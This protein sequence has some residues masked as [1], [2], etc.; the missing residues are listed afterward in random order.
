MNLY[1]DLYE[2]N[3][4]HMG[5][6]QTHRPEREGHTFAINSELGRG[7]YWVYPCGNLFAVSDM[8][9]QLHRN[10][11]MTFHQPVD[12]HVI[13]HYETACGVE[14]PGRVPINSADVR[15]YLPYQESY[16]ILYSSSMPIR[17][18]SITLL[19]DFY[20]E[21]LH[22]RYAGETGEVGA[23][24]D[25]RGP[26]QNL[27]GLIR[28]LGEIRRCR[29]TG[30]AAKLFY[31]SKVLE[32]LSLI[33]RQAQ[34]DGGRPHAVPL[35]SVR[36]IEQV[37][38]YIAR[39]PGDEL[40]IEGLA[41]QACMCV[42][43]FKQAFKAVTGQTVCEYITRTR[44]EKARELLQLPGCAVAEVAGSVGYKK[45]GAFA[46]AYRSVTGQLPS[47]TRRAAQA[48]VAAVIG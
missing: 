18:A 4:C 31:E 34:G 15:A 25:G 23:L 27:P 29:G 44:M 5:F 11:R 37:K 24:L 38:A 7:Y 22:A 45:P 3:L 16:E 1:R 26:L 12:M 17:G 46:K 6:E 20:E 42:T 10:V 30:L 43:K 47:E 36:S 39:N 13:G 48:P 32:A 14:L 8:S 28:V 19:P 41:R 2:S 35:D 21:Y 40:R 9:L 33:I